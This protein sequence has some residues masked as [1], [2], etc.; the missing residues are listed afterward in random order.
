MA[1]LRLP[2]VWC[3]AL[4]LQAPQRHWLWALSEHLSAAEC[5]QLSLLWSEE[6][7]LVPLLLRFLLCSSSKLYSEHPRYC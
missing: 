4:L 2:T 5:A 7:F 1:G 6:I 3:S